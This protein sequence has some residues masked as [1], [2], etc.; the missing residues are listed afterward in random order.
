M[1]NETGEKCDE[2][3]VGGIKINL[4]EG[5]ELPFII[6]LRLWFIYVGLIFLLSV[7]LPISAKTIAETNHIY[8]KFEASEDYTQDNGTKL[9]EI[10]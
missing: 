4:T 9:L 1:D 7:A 10:D 6:Q 2:I 3:L 5:K 8:T